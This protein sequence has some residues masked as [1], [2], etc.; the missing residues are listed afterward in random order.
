[1]TSSLRE[2]FDVEANGVPALGDIDAA[3]AQVAM[4]RRRWRLGGLAA[5]AAI[6]AVALVVWASGVTTRTSDSRPVTSPSPSNAVVTVHIQPNP[7]ALEGAPLPNGAD[8]V[9]RRGAPWGGTLIA[10]SGDQQRTVLSAFRI[11]QFALSPSGRFL[12]WSGSA[13][14]EDILHVLDLTTGHEVF[15]KPILFSSGGSG[16]TPDLEW[17]GDSRRLVMVVLLTA[18][19]DQD[20]VGEVQVF[21]TDATGHLAQVGRAITLPGPFVGTDPTGSTIAAESKAGTFLTRQVVG[22]SWTSA[23]PT[24]VPVTP[25]GLEP[26]TPNGPPRALAWI[27]QG[28]HRW[29]AD[30]ARISWVQVTDGSTQTNSTIGWV[31]LSTG[32][33]RTLTVPGAPAYA[34]G[35]HGTD[36]V[37][38]T[39]AE[40]RTDIVSVGADGIANA[41]ASYALGSTVADLSVALDRLPGSTG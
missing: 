22:G 37:V 18:N 2:Q 36:L 19:I 33:W 9:V 5:V 20:T 34:V 21:D 32:Q 8:V 3:L 24:N 10:I 29:S 14:A 23:S 4:E 30:L 25:P 38:Q 31:S 1:V 15:T 28:S 6:A 16:Q 26:Q 41:V 17:S 39:H 35:W 13:S 7:A 12:A 27:D 40:S 11:Y